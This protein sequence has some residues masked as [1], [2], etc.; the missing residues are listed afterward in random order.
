MYRSPLNCAFFAEARSARRRVA[1]TTSSLLAAALVLGGCS[2]VAGSAEGA[3]GGFASYGA[4]H[5]DTGE[6]SDSAGDSASSGDDLPADDLPPAN[7]ACDPWLQDCPPNERCAWVGADDAGIEPS[8]ERVPRCVPVEGEPLDVG[9]TCQVLGGMD[10]CQRGAQCAFPD[11]EG[12]GVCMWLCGGTPSAPECDG[13]AFCLP[14]PECPSLCLPGCDPLDS[15]TCHEALTCAPASNEGP[16]VCS[17]DAS[18][19]GGGGFKSQCEFANECDDGFDCVDAKSVPGCDYGRCCTPYCELPSGGGANGSD[20]NCPGETT[21]QP[22]S[23]S[24][25]LDGYENLGI[26]KAPV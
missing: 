20:N 13:A 1:A 3:D 10:R 4:S 26:C 18:E 14:C 8:S 21:C 19:P 12:F 15:E 23:P 6:A 24:G 9:E 5:G 22:W 7:E 2:A 25:Q 17:L 11:A 16:F